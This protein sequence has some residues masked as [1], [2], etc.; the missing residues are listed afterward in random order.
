[1]I[2]K[3]TTH[4]IGAGG[5]SVQDECGIAGGAGREGLYGDPERT[6]GDEAGVGRD[7]DGWVDDACLF[8]LFV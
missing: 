1:M 7:V 6:W 3:V 8:T 5:V 4:R 2:F